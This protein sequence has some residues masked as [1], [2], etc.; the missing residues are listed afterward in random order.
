MPAGYPIATAG[1][2]WG[3]STWGRSTWGSGSTSPIFQPARLIFMDKFNN[4]LV[5]NVF[6]IK[7]SISL[8]VLF[9]QVHTFILYKYG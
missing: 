7:D 1:Y 4:D 3:T 8:N 6:S 9:V 2:G 5:F